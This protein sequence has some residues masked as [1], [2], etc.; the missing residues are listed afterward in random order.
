MVLFIGVSMHLKLRKTCEFSTPPSEFF[1][2]G[3]LSLP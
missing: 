1:D 3:N 2:K